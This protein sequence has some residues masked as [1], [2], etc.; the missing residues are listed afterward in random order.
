MQSIS[1]PISV[2]LTAPAHNTSTLSESEA[3]DALAAAYAAY[4]AYAASVEQDRAM[5]QDEQSVQEPTPD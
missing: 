2:E 4:A 5:A 1:T 3:E